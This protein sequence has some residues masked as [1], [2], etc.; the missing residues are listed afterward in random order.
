MSSDPLDSGFTRRQFTPGTTVFNRHELTERIGFGKRG[1][2]WK[3]RDP[4]LADMQVA[5]KLMPGNKRCD[6]IK[7]G[8]ERITDLTHPNIVRTYGFTG[9]KELCGFILEPVRGQGVDSLLRGKEPPF[10]EVA[11]VRPWASQLF[12]ALQF[13]WEHGRVVHGDLRLPNLFITTGG[14]LKVSEY[15]FAL[16]RKGRP[17]TE[18]DFLS[19]GFSL[20]CL[21]PQVIEGEV[22]THSDDIYAAAACL[23]EMLTGKPVFLSGNIMAQI[24]TRVPP[25]IA[26]RRAELGLQGAPV[27][28]AWEALIARCLSKNRADRPAT[29]AEVVALIETLPDTE[30]RATS[31]AKSLTTAVTTVMKSSAG[32]R[33]VLLHPLAIVAA[34]LLL[35]A[36]AVQMLVLSPRNKALA[37]LVEARRDL[38]A[39]D[40]AARPDQAQ[41]RFTAWEKFVSANALKPIPFTDEDETIITHASD[42]IAFYQAEVVKA[43]DEAKKKADELAMKTTRFA[44]ALAAQKQADTNPTFTIADRLSAWTAMQKD[45]GA[46]GHPDTQ[47]YQALLA[48]VAAQTKVWQQ[49][50]AE[51]KKK[52]DDEAARMAN[53]I[54]LAEQAAARW[55]EDRN[56]AWAL[57]SAKC[58]DPIVSPS[59]KAS[60]VAAFLTTLGN[61]PAGP[62]TSKRA[63]ELLA[64]ATEAQA[65]IQ[66][67]VPPPDKPLKEEELLAESPVKDQPEAVRKAFVFLMQERLKAAGHY[68]GKPDGDHG[69]GS[70]TALVEYQKAG[71]L[72]TNGKLD[73]PT[74]KAL[75]MDQPDLPALAAS[76]KKLLAANDDDSPQRPRK[77]RQTQTEEEAGA[78]RQILNGFRDL[79]KGIGQGFKK[80]F[81]K[82]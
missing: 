77:K 27:P 42:R 5:L 81:S 8:I 46:A 9:D 38:D 51:V 32:V 70:H 44:K 49:K 39:A 40:A 60:E 50:E 28:K 13:A 11:E 16:Q 10:F 78:G 45:F 48:D 26:E 35:G 57:V 55:I 43:E 41:E 65:K 61:P 12:A 69:P 80:A 31:P 73:A 36:L 58:V 53:E 59:V 1:E 14:S 21:S 66:S 29:A 6:D 2:V 3:A 20:P 64:L 72:I 17:L 82:D 33:S 23:Y 79:G 19:G 47:A 25:S 34:V 15:W 68:Q 37:A 67:A 52:A 71:K 7:D 4:K 24:L 54:K 74:L 76:G 22:P 18:R 63:A 56:S 62:Q 75:G 30:T